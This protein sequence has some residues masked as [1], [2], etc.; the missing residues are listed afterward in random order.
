MNLSSCFW[1]RSLYSFLISLLESFTT[2]SRSIFFCIGFEIEHIRSLDL[3]FRSDQGHGFGNK[4]W[5]PGPG[6]SLIILLDCLISSPI[7]TLVFRPEWIRVNFG[8]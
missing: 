3:Y 1:I 5:S 7:L 2:P 6:V 8:L 4:L